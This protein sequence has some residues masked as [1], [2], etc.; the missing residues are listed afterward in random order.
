MAVFSLPTNTVVLV[1][2]GD[3]PETFALKDK[4]VGTRGIAVLYSNGVGRM[5]GLFDSRDL[6]QLKLL[7]LDGAMQVRFGRVPERV[8]ISY[9][10]SGDP[11]ML[12]DLDW[13]SSRAAAV[14]RYA[15]YEV[16]QTLQIDDA[17]LVVA[18]RTRTDAWY[19]DDRGDHRL[20]T[21]GQTYSVS[22][23][24]SG[25]ALL[26][27]GDSAG[28]LDVWLLTPDGR[29]ERLTRVGAA[30]APAFDGAGRD[31]AYTDYS[32]QSIVWCADLSAQTCRVVYRD[33]SLPTAPAFS[34]DGRLLSIM[35]QLRQPKV[36]VLSNP[37]GGTVGSWDGSTRCPP[38]WSRAGTVWTLAAPG[39]HFLW[40]EHRPDGRKTGN[41]VPFEEG[42]SRGEQCWPAGVAGP[43]RI[44]R[45]WTV[46]EEVSRL[47]K[48]SGKF[49]E[50]HEPVH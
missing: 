19:A 38:I 29:Q 43:L 48:V 13:R 27:R 6:H 2:G 46:R 11:A 3:V 22:I 21:D 5:L 15:G 26:G 10:A 35:T 8:L 44:R 1:P 45:S 39:G 32:G 20:T 49:L 9:Q 40:I 33:A 47:L 16:S 23:R 7:N 31:W 41:T 18:R 36:I 12:V 30:A 17:T 14:G 24:G 50:A 25:E 4:A 34:P 28:H 37:Q 42:A